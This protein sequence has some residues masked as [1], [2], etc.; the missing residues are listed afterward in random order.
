[1]L[2]VLALCGFDAQLGPFGQPEMAITGTNI[3]RF[4]IPA[5]VSGIILVIMIFY[6]LK[7]YFPAIAEMKAKMAAEHR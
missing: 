5:A 2:A 7:K 3:V 6:P 4:A 1:M